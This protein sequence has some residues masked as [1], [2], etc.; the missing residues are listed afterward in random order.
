MFA[1]DL[2]VGTLCAGVIGLVTLWASPPAVAPAH[3]QME[4]LDCENIAEIYRYRLEVGQ[5]TAEAL[6][7]LEARNCCVPDQPGTCPPAEADPPAEP[8]RADPNDVAAPPAGT[9]PP[10]EAGGADP[11]DV[12]AL[13]DEIAALREAL[14]EAEDAL[15]EARTAIRQAKAA[16]ARE[17]A[18]LE[19]EVAEA[20]AAQREAEAAVETAEAERDEAR[21]EAAGS[22]RRARLEAGARRRL[23]RVVEEAVQRAVDRHLTAE[24]VA[25]CSDIAV[26]TVAVPPDGGAVRLEVSGVSPATGLVDVVRDIALPGVGIDVSVDRSGGLG[27]CPLRLGRFVV[28]TTDGRVAGRP[29][30]EVIPVREQLAAI[31]LC[32]EIGALIERADAFA[33]YRAEARVRGAWVATRDR[34]QVF[35]GACVLRDGRYTK[36]Y[37]DHDAAASYV[38]VFA[39][40]E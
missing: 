11:Q 5:D 9:D 31:D 30:D 19:G 34:G 17:V 13:Q 21:L 23:Q 6:A 20:N 3:A 14:A 24:G 28:A 32:A 27:G 38:P 2:R 22:R 16:H 8:G 10:A 26:R 35:V 7:A 36:E 1:I 15:I 29:I 25:A 4:L 40:G 39:G 18:A 37:R 12:A 33:P